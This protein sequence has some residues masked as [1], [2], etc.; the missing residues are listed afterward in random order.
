MNKDTIL[1]LLEERFTENEAYHPETDWSIVKETLSEK[2]IETLIK[3]EEKQGAPALVR[4]DDEAY[5]FF[6]TFSEVPEIRGNVTYDQAGEDARKKENLPI[7]G[8]A[9]T[10]AE[11]MGSELLNEEDYF[12]L[13][14]LNDF[15]LKTSVWIETPE[16]VRKKGG[17]LFGDKRY[18]RAFIYHNGAKSFYKVRGYRTKLKVLK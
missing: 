1:T 11:E 18:G 17:A 10:L 6:D 16:A 12:Y 3:M 9:K 8:N 5:Y 14:S 4:E 15:D 7:K 13:Q 2:D